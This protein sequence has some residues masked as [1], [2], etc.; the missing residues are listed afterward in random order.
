LQNVLSTVIVIF[1]ITLST[2]YCLTVV[3]PQYFR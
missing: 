2:I 3:F 1:F